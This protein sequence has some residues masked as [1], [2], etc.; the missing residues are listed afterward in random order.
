MTNIL[1]SDEIQI[2]Q[3]HK[4]EILNLQ[5]N[6]PLIETS[7]FIKISSNFHENKHTNVAKFKG[8]NNFYNFLYANK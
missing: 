2:A 5:E 3:I 7:Y 6:K 1:N 4:E 8:K